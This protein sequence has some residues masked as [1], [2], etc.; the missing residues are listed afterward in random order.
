MTQGTF[1]PL[2]VSDARDLGFDPDRLVRLEASLAADIEKGTCNGIALVVGRAGKTALVSIQGYADRAEGRELGADDVLV[3]FS[4]G[5]QFTGVTVLNYIERGLLQLHRP[6]AEV[7]PEFGVNGKAKINLA[8]LLTHTSGIPPFAPTEDPAGDYDLEKYVAAICQTAPETLP[9]Q[10]VKYSIT[11]A[12]SVMAEMVRRVDG[13]NRPFRQIVEEEVF[14]PLGM[15]DT[16][17]GKPDRLADRVCPVV[18][19]DHSPGL[20]DPAMLEGTAQGLTPESEMPAGGYVTTIS[21]FARFAEMLRNGG[22]LDGVRILSP[23][24]ISMAT[25]NQTGDM[26][27]DIWNYCVE[28][29]NWPVFPANL[30]LGF[31]LRGEGTFPTPFGSL[32]SPRTFG[33]IGAGSTCFHIDPER[34]MFVAFLSTGLLEESRS[35]ERHQRVADMVHAALVD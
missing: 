21:D 16:A 34:D 5:K 11:T 19:T 4:S 14:L 33:G 12:H 29:R 10:A 18:V 7:I 28:T 8:H 22:S 1:D 25:T 9:G 26:P 6:V 24:M 3:T 27:N 35:T 32:A 31:F 13:G 20:L 15:K 2:L 23:G 17:L 30:G